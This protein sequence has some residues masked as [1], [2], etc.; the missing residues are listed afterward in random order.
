MWVDKPSSR[1]FIPVL[2]M[3]TFMLLWHRRITDYRAHSLKYLLSGPPQSKFV[4]L[5]NKLVRAGQGGSDGGGCRGVCVAQ[6]LEL[7]DITNRLSNGQTIPMQATCKNSLL[8][9]AK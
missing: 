9:R 2:S 4:N 5:W 8:K 7:F 3:A 1:P 6:E